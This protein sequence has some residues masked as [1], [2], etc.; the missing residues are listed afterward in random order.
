VLLC[1]TA[2][3]VVLCGQL[4]GKVNTARLGQ[5][6]EEIEKR[7]NTEDR[8]DAALRGRPCWGPPARAT[9]PLEAAQGSPL[10]QRQRL[11]QQKGLG[12]AGAGRGR[13]IAK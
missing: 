8:Y 11:L 9:T 6:L 4:I 12:G 10:A 2:G 13:R 3:R 7:E 5:M 1:C